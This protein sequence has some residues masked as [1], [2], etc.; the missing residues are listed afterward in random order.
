MN[1][2]EVE[3]LTKNY[4]GNPRAA[5]DGISFEVRHGEVFGML[6]PNGAGKTTTVGVLTT[7]VRPS[8]GRVVVEGLDVLREPTRAR[9]V[10]AVVPQR[11]N[12]DRSLS[13]RQ[14]LHC[15]AAYHAVPR[16]E[17]RRRADE[18]LERMGLADRAGDRA[19]RLSGGQAQRVMIAR[20][21]MHEPR[22]LFLDEPSGG[23]DPQSRLFVHE[24]IAELRERGVTVVL[25][26]HQMGEAAKLCDRVAILDHGK[27]LALDTPGALVRE[28]P[29]SNTLTL[30]LDS[31]EGAAAAALAAVETVERVEELPGGRVRL[32]TSHDPGEV[33]PTVVKALAGHDLT[34]AGV[35]FARLGLEDVFLRLTGR[36]LR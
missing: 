6:G 32:Y 35:E 22:V 14:V 24:R 1:A 20:A 2:V 11:T 34:L 4:R 18:L 16:A 30:A 33:L 12:L 21:L 3:N 19:D 31:A 15:H 36:E 10:L 29:S 8:G 27:V 9:Q 5:V 23:L 7:R 28:L 26:T 25:T 13:I 17:R